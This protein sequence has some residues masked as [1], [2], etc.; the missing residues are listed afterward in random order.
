MEKLFENVTAYSSE[1][2]Q[3]FE[4]FHREKYN[5]SYGS[6]T[7]FIIILLLFCSIANFSSNNI[8]L[9]FLF[10]LVLIC[11]VGWRFLHP[12]FLVKKETTS[13]KIIKQL[14]NKFSFYKNKMKITNKEGS[15]YFYYWK[16]YKVYETSDYF[17]LYMTKT[18]S[19]V[20]S[21]QCFTLGT[22]EDFASF[23]K[24]KTM[25]NYKKQA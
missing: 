13:E 17:Y 18:H 10:I 22:P 2:Y 5:F 12:Y 11:F 16:L 1:I 24:K 8:G 25:F 6:Y 20:L 15:F 21:K 4:T 3:Q 23:M 7:L 14:K 9:G 19:F